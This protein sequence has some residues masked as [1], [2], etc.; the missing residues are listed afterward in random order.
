MKI[1][2]LEEDFGGV[3]APVISYGTPTKSIITK[4]KI[5]KQ[6]LASIIKK[7]KNVKKY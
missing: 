1:H 4:Y 5:D 3:G 7:E 2:K 6:K